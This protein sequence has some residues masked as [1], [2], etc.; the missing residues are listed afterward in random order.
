MLMQTRSFFKKTLARNILPGLESGEFTPY[1]QP[2]IDLVSKKIKG[3]EATARWYASGVGWISPAEFIPVAE[4]TGAII[5]LGEW[6]LFAACKQTKYWQKN[7]FPEL[8]VSVNI[9]PFQLEEKNI[10]SKVEGIL[11]QTGLDAK[12]LELEVTETVLI[13]N[14]LSNLQA[15]NAF[16]EMGIRLA[17]DDFGTGYSSLGYLTTFPFEILKLDQ[18]FARSIHLSQTQMVIRSM[19]NLGRQL[20]LSTILTGIEDKKELAMARHLGCDQAQ[21]HAILPPQPAAEI[22]LAMATMQEG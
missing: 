16:K 10:I 12:F 19:A 21:G 15:L 6:L 4:S 22:T 11:A 13:K 17:I 20:G 2:K 5:P 3:L 1:Y 8:S 14:S 18:I 9:S 7:G